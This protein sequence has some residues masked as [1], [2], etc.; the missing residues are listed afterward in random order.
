MTTVQSLRALGMPDRFVLTFSTPANRQSNLDQFGEKI[1]V[2]R[3]EAVSGSRRAASSSLLLLLDEM[4]EIEVLRRR[5]RRQVFGGA[6]SILEILMQG[7]NR[8]LPIQ[9]IE[10]NV[11]HFEHA[12]DH[13]GEEILSAHQST[14]FVALVDI[15]L[16]AFVE[17]DHE[18]RVQRQ[19]QEHEQLDG[20]V[21]GDAEMPANRR[22]LPS[23][24]DDFEEA[25]VLVLVDAVIDDGE[26]E[27]ELRRDVVRERNL[28]VGV[29]E[30]NL[31]RLDVHAV[32]DEGAGFD[33]EE[34]DD[35]L[36]VHGLLSERRQ[37][38][39]AVLV[40]ARRE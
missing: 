17:N 35:E 3:F 11:G 32:E 39:L 25:K 18:Q 33:A 4:N 30:M 10:A 38:V 2:D 16:V 31:G 28:I 13:V 36:R 15:Q 6:R 26:T 20:A 9:Y 22:V 29:V 34:H 40:H 1:L 27:V 24:M 14:F 8:R 19:G 37:T 23:T 5:R 21:P 12:Q 7:V